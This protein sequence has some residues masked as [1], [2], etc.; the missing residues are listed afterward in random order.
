MIL[1]PPCAAKAAKDGDST[2]SQE[3]AAVE[4]M[5]FS[6]VIN[7]CLRKRKAEFDP[8]SI[9]DVEKPKSKE[10]EFD[11]VTEPPEW[12]VDSFDGLDY[13][14]SSSPTESLLSDE[15]YSEDEEAMESYRFSKRQIIES[16]DSPLEFV[17]LVRGNYRPGGARERSYI[18]F[19]AREK[20]GERPVEYQAKCMCTVDGKTH[21]ILCRPAPPPPTPKAFSP[22]LLEV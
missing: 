13:V 7:P 9:D 8:E 16:K 15:K 5:E 6:S 4:T 17:E 10:A 20:P 1:T 21:P 3:E 14:S 19:M 18:T 2:K 22:K 11:I 12:D